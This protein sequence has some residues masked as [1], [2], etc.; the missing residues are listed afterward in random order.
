MDRELRA[1]IKR[2][3]KTGVSDREI[4]Q[5]G[6]PAAK[7]VRARGD[8]PGP[9]VVRRYE[10]VENLNLGA[11]NFQNRSSLRMI[12]DG[13]GAGLF[14]ACGR[15]HYRLSLLDRI[16]R[17]YLEKLGRWLASHDIG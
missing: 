5:R 17:G 3:P 6:S 12:A 7:R 11:A 9:N 2:S 14:R 10:V 13:V 16:V 1:I 15:F 8:G 4:G